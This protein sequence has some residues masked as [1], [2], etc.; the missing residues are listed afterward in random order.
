[1]IDRLA[2]VAAQ[3]DITRKC[4]IA[5][6]KSTPNCSKSSKARASP[7]TDDQRK[8]LGFPWILLAEMSLFKGLRRPPRAKNLI[9]LQSLTIGLAE[10][11][12]SFPS[13]RQ[14]NTGF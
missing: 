13:I 8:K 14:S 9:S 5:S 7:S 4:F 2:L 1:M 11:A 6:S 10:P 3:L 12:L